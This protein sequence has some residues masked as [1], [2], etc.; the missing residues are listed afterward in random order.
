[1]PLVAH[2]PRS[3][4]QSRNRVDVKKSRNA[5]LRSSSGGEDCSFVVLQSGGATDQ[6]TVGLYDLLILACFNVYL[7]NA[8]KKELGM[9]SVLLPTG[10]H[11]SHEERW[12]LGK[13]QSIGLRRRSPIKGICHDLMPQHVQSPV[14][15]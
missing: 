3:L 14:A 9:P 7:L 6:V 13:T 10:L 5:Q 15:L 2:T 4:R 11:V 8:S 1:M 12:P